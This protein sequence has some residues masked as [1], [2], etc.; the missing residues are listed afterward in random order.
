MDMVVC[1]AASADVEHLCVAALQQHAGVASKPALYSMCWCQHREATGRRQ[2]G[3][4]FDC[5]GSL[6]VLQ[7]WSGQEPLTRVP[8]VLQWQ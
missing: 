1:M 2:K 6:L 5:R 3:V 8:H 4:Q 7:E